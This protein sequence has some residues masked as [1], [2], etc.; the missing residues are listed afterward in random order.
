MRAQGVRTVV[1]LRSEAPG[2]PG[3]AAR[4]SGMAVGRIPVRDGRTPTPQQGRRRARRAGRGRRRGAGGG[5][6]CGGGRRR[7][8]RGG[9]AVRAG[10]GR[11]VRR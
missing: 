5:R 4:A 3:P 9:A 11:G 6:A 1:D 10:S 8:R 7:R 2:A